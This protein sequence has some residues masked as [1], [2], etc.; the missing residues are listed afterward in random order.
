[1]GRDIESMPIL[2]I[3][4]MLKDAE[5]ARSLLDRGAVGGGLVEELANHVEALVDELRK[6]SAACAL[7]HQHL[8]AYGVV[9]GQHV[10]R[11]VESQ[12]RVFEATG[13]L[14]RAVGHGFVPL[15]PEEG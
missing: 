8:D 5:E 12:E 7:A 6:A 4:Q 14:C 3:G 1:M 10:E 2:P 15:Y 11:E 9:S 13:P